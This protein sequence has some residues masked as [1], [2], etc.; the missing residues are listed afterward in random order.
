MVRIRNPPPKGPRPAPPDKLKAVRARAWETRRRKY[1]AHG[2]SGI[3]KAYSR[4]SADKAALI[5]R[6]QHMEGYLVK[7][8]A[9]GVISEGQAAK[10]TGLH[11]IELR[12][13]VDE[14]AVAP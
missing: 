10:A 4:H 8:L 12:R 7:L 13:R 3:G 5:D 2:H 6:I 1:G 11:R 9:H 14:M